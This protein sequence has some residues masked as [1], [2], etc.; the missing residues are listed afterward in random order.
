[1]SSAKKRKSDYTE[2]WINVVVR[3]KTHDDLKTLG[4]ATSSFNEIIENLLAEKMPLIETIKEARSA[5][6]LLRASN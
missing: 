6:P 3:K 1:M 2:Q 5:K 4:D